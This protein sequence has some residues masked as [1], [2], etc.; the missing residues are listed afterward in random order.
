MYWNPTLIFSD[1]CLTLHNITHTSTFGSH[2]QQ[3][4]LFPVPCGMWAH[5][6]CSG[7]DHINT[8]IPSPGLTIGLNNNRTWVSLASKCWSNTLPIYQK[9]FEWYRCVQW[10]MSSCSLYTDAVA[11]YHMQTTADSRF[12]PSQWETSLQSNAISHWLGTNLESALQTTKQSYQPEHCFN[13]NI[14]MPFH[15]YMDSHGLLR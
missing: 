11:F 15:L 14:K 6:H 8:G 10:F 5:S 12:T 13:Q 4:H 9:T 7:P 3:R 1:D 2:H